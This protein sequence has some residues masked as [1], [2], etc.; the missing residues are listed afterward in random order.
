[1]RKLSHFVLAHKVAATLVAVATVSVGALGGTYANFTATPVTISNN[2]F[3][4]GT[5][6]IGRSGSG[7]IF[8]ATNQ[9]IGQ[10]STGSVTIQ[11]TGSMDGLFTLSSSATGDLASAL[12]LVI[13][14]D[15]DLG[16]KL[17]DGTL[18]GMSSADLGVIAQGA[19]ST[20]YFHVLLPSTGSDAGDNA[21]QGKTASATF[22]W[23]AVQA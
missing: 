14:K 1:M 6:T 20:F 7:A 9:K 21:L 8:N 10:D 18:S 16:T 5:L 12:K 2:A 22:T 13:Y 17:Y 15:K 11:N 23:N 3:A 4:T 19:S